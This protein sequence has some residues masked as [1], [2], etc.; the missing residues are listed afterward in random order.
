[1]TGKELEVAGKGACKYTVIGK[2]ACSSGER[3]RSGGEKNSRDREGSLQRKSLQRG[4]REGS[5]QWSTKS[6]TVRSSCRFRS[7]L[8]FPLTVRKYETASPCSQRQ[9]TIAILPRELCPLALYVSLKAPAVARATASAILLSNRTFPKGVESCLH[10]I[11]E[12]RGDIH[13]P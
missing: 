7:S 9:R 4:D 1:V 8:S 12:Q 6:V 2:G 5:L 11:M 13:A 10:G 3:G